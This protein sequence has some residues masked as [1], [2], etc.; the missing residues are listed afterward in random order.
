M[1]I[2]K[3]SQAI[4]NLRKDY[5]ESDLAITMIVIDDEVHIQEVAR[6]TANPEQPK[7]D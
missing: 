2:S 4:E 6:I 1:K 7:N 5:L 3:V